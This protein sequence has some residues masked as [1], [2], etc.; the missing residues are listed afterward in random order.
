MAEITNARV[1]RIA[2]PIVLSNATVPILGAVDTGVVGQ[3][4][5]AAP[6]GAVG[7]GAIILASVYWIF[8]FLRMGTSGLA[9]QAHGA[10]DRAESGA[11]LLRGLGVGVAA[12]L[13]LIAL[14]VPLVWAAF[15]I[16]PASAEVEALARDYLAIRIWGAPATISLYAVTGWLIALERTRGVLALQLWMNGLNIAL[17]LWFVLG[18]GWGCR[19]WPSPR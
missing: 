6:I 8:G 12:G 15:R 19:G 16:A 10:G 17:D 1:L 14:Q 2:A 3:M 7:I 18:L 13:L 9:A 4:G 11:V 5:L